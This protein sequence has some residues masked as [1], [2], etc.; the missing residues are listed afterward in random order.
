MEFFVKHRKI[1]LSRIGICMILFF[2]GITCTRENQD[3]KVLATVN[4]FELTLEDFERQLTADVEMTPDFKLT[5]EAK[6]HFLNQ[7]IRKEILIQEAMKRKLDRREA[8][9]RA[10]E[11]Y[12]QST[13]IRDLLELKGDEI[14]K[15]I[16]VSEEEIDARYDQMKKAN[17]KAPAK[18]EIRGKI[19][20][21]LKEEKRTKKLKEWI[22]DLQKGTTITID[23]K[24]LQVDKG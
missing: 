1:L 17:E 20:S 4:D 16:Y 10:I 24:L 3:K 22:E 15:Q 9:I 2:F 12:W 6:E 23:R 14:S 21:E 19:L 5:H 8:F 13:L 11:R 18:D 7:L